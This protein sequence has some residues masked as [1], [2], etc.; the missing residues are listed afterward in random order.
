MRPSGKAVEQTGKMDPELH[1]IL[2]LIPSPPPDWSNLDQFLEFA[3]VRQ[4]KVLEDL[5][6]SISG[7]KESDVL[8]PT[9]DLTKQRAKLYQPAVKPTDGSPLVV[10][11][12]GGGFCT[13]T[14]EGEAITARN[15][16]RAFSAVCVSISYR[17]APQFPFPYAP[18][19][20]WDAL[21]WV[22]ANAASLGANPALGFV[23]GG[24]SAGANLATIVAHLARDA[25]LQP[26][27]TGQFLASPMN[28][29]LSW[30]QNADAPFLPVAA[31]DMF[32]TGYL[33][34]DEDGERFAILAHPRGHT[35][36]PPAYITVSCLDPLRDHGLTYERYPGVPHSR[37][38]REDQ[39]K[40]FSWLLN[41]TPVKLDGAGDAI[42]S[43]A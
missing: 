4:A 22:A 25:G 13:G 17:L 2:Q 23:V 15:L 35:G 1:Q 42:E 20:A 3:N 11:F 30:T 12:H 9:R 14:P 31:V 24:S 5:E 27:L 37:K 33:P 28:Q 16:T 32:M 8:Y 7:V 43:S 6:S 36:I 26:S 41:R 29:Y 39:I 34:D 40:A 38:F 21:K 10:L 19:D 18:N